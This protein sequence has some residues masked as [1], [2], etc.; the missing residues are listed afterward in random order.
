M[1]GDFAALKTISQPL[2]IIGLRRT[3][4]NSIAHDFDI[5]FCSNI[6]I[7]SLSFGIIIIHEIIIFIKYKKPFTKIAKQNILFP[8][9]HYTS[10]FC[11]LILL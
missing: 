8:I 5:T 11:S 2:I 3:S 9:L 7:P 1:T 6:H 10:V 4:S